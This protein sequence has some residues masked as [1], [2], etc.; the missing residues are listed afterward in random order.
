MI[1]LLETMTDVLSMRIE[2]FLY[3]SFLVS[4][5]SNPKLLHH[6]LDLDHI[7]CVEYAFANYNV[8]RMQKIDTSQDYRNSRQVNISTSCY[9]NVNYVG[10]SLPTSRIEWACTLL[11]GKFYPI[12]VTGKQMK[13][14]IFANNNN[15]NLILH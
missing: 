10:V 15:N 12:E 6:D 14:T 2:Y 11:Y 7:K 4:K 9:K 13:H 5:C 1:C 8:N 3:A